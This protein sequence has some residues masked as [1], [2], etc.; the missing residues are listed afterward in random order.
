MEEGQ[1]T[2]STPQE[3]LVPT[4][5][6]QKKKIEKELKSKQKEIAKQEKK[7]KE[8][9]ERENKAKIKEEKKKEKQ[10]KKTASRTNMKANSVQGQPAM[11]DFRWEKELNKNDGIRI[12][13]HLSY[14]RDL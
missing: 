2:V 5:E 3:D 6:K 1:K 10:E 13:N 8:K 11:E 4:T 12:S 7:E 14:V 9:E